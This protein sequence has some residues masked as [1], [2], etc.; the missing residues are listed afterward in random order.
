[1]RTWP[2]TGTNAN[3]VCLRQ[4]YNPDLLDRDHF[5]ALVDRYG[6][7]GRGYPANVTGPGWAIEH[8]TEPQDEWSACAI[9]SQDDLAARF[10]PNFFFGCEADDPFV[11][12]AFDTRL[13]PNGVE[14]S[15]LFGS[16]IGHW[17]VP[18]MNHVLLE[19]WEQ[20]DNGRLSLSHLARFCHHNA[21]AFYEGPNP[22]FFAGTVLEVAHADLGATR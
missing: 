16:D 7:F 1:M 4:N 22:A 12:L 14:L 19:A 8:F 18:V 20:V 11:S 10:V 9:E 13:N 5:R 2:D 15:A 6:G 3:R 21:R 17:D